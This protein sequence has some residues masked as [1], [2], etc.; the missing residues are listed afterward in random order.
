[1]GRLGSACCNKWDEGDQGDFLVVGSELLLFL[2]SRLGPH[3]LSRKES[4]W[5][6]WT[7]RPWTM[8]HG[9]WFIW[10]RHA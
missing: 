3:P 6:S 10:L 2:N 5:F 9:P 7:H 1:M 8:D 4:V